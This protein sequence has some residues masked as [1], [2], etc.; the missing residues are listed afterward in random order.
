[1]TTVQKTTE[2]E[3]GNKIECSNIVLI[4]L[5][6]CLFPTRCFNFSLAS[7]KKVYSNAFNFKASKK[8]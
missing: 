1:M 8:L 4:C 3:D 6:N 5:L 2:R 7:T